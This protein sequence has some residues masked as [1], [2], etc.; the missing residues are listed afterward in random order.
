MKTS[1][2]N[3]QSIDIIKEMGGKAF[4]ITTLQLVLFGI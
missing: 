2:K 3:K 1:T 4:G